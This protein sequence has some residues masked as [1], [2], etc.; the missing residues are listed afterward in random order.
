MSKPQSLSP[1]EVEKIKNITLGWKNQH[2]EF[3]FYFDENQIEGKLPKDLRGTFSRNGPGLLEVYGTELVFYLFFNCKNHPI[4][5][6]GYICT[7]TFEDGKVAFNSKFVD[8]YSH[9]EEKEAQRMLY[10]GNFVFTQIRTNGFK[11]TCF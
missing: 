11:S 2:N 7:I 6:D 5:G 1:T 10:D 9:K 3:S 8:T 4:D